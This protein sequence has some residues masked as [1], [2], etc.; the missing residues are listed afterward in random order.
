[1]PYQSSPITQLMGMGGPK[2]GLQSQAP[3]LL[4]AEEREKLGLPPVQGPKKKQTLDGS[5]NG[6]GK[7]DFLKLLLA[8]LSNQDPLKP[9]EDKEFIAQLAQFNTLE[10]MQQAN[11]HLVEM[12]TS[13]TLAQASALLGKIVVAG[14]TGGLVTAVSMVDGKAQLTVGGKQFP[15]SQIT[16]VLPEQPLTAVTPETI[17]GPAPADTSGAA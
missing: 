8:Q 11:K 14:S 13:Q 5:P 12:V 7:E 3:K 17:Q 2:A 6:L 9:M 10:Q 1:M 4:S 15:L 16:K